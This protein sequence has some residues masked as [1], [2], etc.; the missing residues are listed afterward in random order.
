MLSFSNGIHA[1]IQKTFS[2]LQYP[3]YRQFWISQMLSQT[4]S[5]IQAT[6]QQYLVLEL[7]GNSSTLL[8]T[9]T[10][11]QFL[12]TLFLSLFA[13]AFIDRFPRKW[14][15]LSTQTLFLT[16]ALVLATTTYLSTVN[17]HLIMAMAL[18]N[19]IAN[20]FDVPARQSMVVDFIPKTQV[21]NAIAL[22]SLAFNISRT[23]GQSLFGAIAA[24][25]S[26]LVMKNIFPHATSVSTAHLSLP[27]ILNAFSFFYVLYVISI[28][29]F[30]KREK[31]GTGRILTDISE[32]FQF[33][34]SQP[35]IRNII[36]LLGILSLTTLNFNVI[37]PYFSRAIYHDSELM[38]GIVSASFGVGAVFGALW[39]A[40]RAN[41]SRN[42]RI[43]LIVT[44]IGGIS[45]AFVQQSIHALPFLIMSGF[46]MLCI[47][48]SANSIVQL[49]VPDSLRGRVMSVYSFV[50]IGMAPA[51]AYLTS[52][53][54]GEE[55]GLGAQKGLLLLHGL[56]IITTLLF[57][58][59]LPRQ[60]L[61]VTS[62]NKS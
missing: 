14:V 9:V 23:I 13:G 46:G 39:Q 31:G 40:T 36:F 17:I 60:Q 59:H 43:G 47:L 50:L 55:W 16:V 6:A 53:L 21:V 26:Y 1:W 33:I 45:M 44:S 35:S 2:A 5:W 20:A 34:K 3:H 30:P 4:G 61:A 62:L 56:G 54:I 29:P 28:L 8:G 11:F 22:N 38:F 12:P 42:I 32:G 41:P 37:I 15:L 27:F 18:L 49:S 58:K 48:T 25:G 19:G 51:G 57:W 10:M 24:L 7:T 52:H